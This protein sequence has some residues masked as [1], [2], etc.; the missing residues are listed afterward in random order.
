MIVDLADLTPAQLDRLVEL[1]FAAGAPNSPGWLPTLE[2]AREMIDEQRDKLARVVLEDDL[3]VA[4]IAAGHDWGRLWEI[5]PLLVAPSHQRR[6]LGRMLVREIETAAR[7]DGA[8]TLT[9]STSDMTSAT[10]LSNVDLFDDPARRIAELTSGPSHP[11]AFW[12]ALGFSV[13]GVTPDAEGPGM[14]SISF[15]KRL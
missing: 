4:W 6:G 12:V 2:R 11:V 5:H 8:L 3:P 10:S 1:S 9:L 7:A 13:V 15:A 14:P